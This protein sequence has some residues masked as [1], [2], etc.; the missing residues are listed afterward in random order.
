VVKRGEYGAML[1]T[2]TSLFI[3]P[4]FPVDEVVDP[5]G[6]GDSFA[7]ALIGTL[8]KEK[9]NRHHL[10]NSDSLLKKAVINGCVMASFTVQDFSIKRLKTLHPEEFQKREE[11]FYKMLQI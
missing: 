2:Q 9:L 3:A 1:F 7:G 5:T 10:K 6:A 4:A 8:A 11:Q